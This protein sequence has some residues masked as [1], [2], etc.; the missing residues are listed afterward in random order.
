MRISF[1]YQNFYLGELILI[2]F[3]VFVQAQFAPAAGQI[4][5]SA[6]S[7][8]S[9]VIMSWAQTCIIERGLQNILDSSLGY[10]TVGNETSATDVALENGVVSL[11]DG[12][13]ITCTFENI[14]KNESGP[15]FAVF[16]N[17]FDDYFLELAFV[18]VSSDGIHFQ[19][20]PAISNTQTETQIT[21]F[22]SLNPTLIHNLAGKY[23]GGYGTPFELEDLA[24]DTLLDLQHI[25]HIR[26]RDV[27]GILDSSLGSFDSNGHFVNE[28]FPTPFPS[29][30][31]DLDA[32]GVI[33]QTV[34]IMDI[35]NTEH[36]R[37]YPNPCQT[38]QAFYIQGNDVKNYEV[39]DM[40]GQ[41]INTKNK[42][43]NPGIYLINI[44]LKNKKLISKTL[45]IL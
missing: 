30:G 45:V 9:S 13:S 22:D 14:I 19:R 11:G 34:G 20:F 10:T 3:P 28:P 23:R 38:N 32:I 36:I 35:K 4:G 27:V 15:D 8:D 42:L 44:E 26:I 31:F 17:G 18:E 39:Y 29:G 33:H 21:S 24:N 6:I 12:G 41:K 25:T 5:T 40:Y 2:L 16:E 37:L 1:I 43:Q 7:K